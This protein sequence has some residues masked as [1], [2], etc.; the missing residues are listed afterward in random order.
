MAKP[1]RPA[2]WSPEAEQDLIEISSYWAREAS[3]EVADDQL[4][5]IDRACERL[6]EWPYSSRARD[7]LVAGLR[8]L[9]V[10]PNVIFYRVRAN[11]VEIVRVID[12]HRD[13]DRIFTEQRND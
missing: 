11:D 13:I 9:V 3:V 5:G 12:G 8:S 7:E 6:E 2:V 10:Y 1:R 4:R